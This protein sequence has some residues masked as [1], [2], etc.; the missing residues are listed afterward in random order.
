M[1][2][3][4]T[5]TREARLKS[6]AAFYDRADRFSEICQSKKKLQRI[7]TFSQ[8]YFSDLHLV[9]QTLAR[10]QGTHVVI[11]GPTGCLSMLPEDIGHLVQTSDWIVTGINERDVILGGEEKLR[12]ALKQLCS[13][14]HSSCIFVVTTPPVSVN[15][16]DVD[17][18]ANEFGS[19][20]SIPI[21]VIPATGF[22]SKLGVMGYDETQNVLSLLMTP[23]AS[24]PA[25]PYVNLISVS[26]SARDVGEAG[27]FLNRL[28][29]AV[30]ILPNF[31]GRRQLALASGARAS[32]VLNK[33]ESGCLSDFLQKRYGVPVLSFSPPVG[34]M[35]TDVWEHAVADA[36]D[37]ELPQKEQ[38]MI[39][40]NTAEN[41]Q[42][43]NVYLMVDSWYAAPYKVFLE[44]L[45]AR[46]CGITVPFLEPSSS[47][48]ETL[49]GSDAVPIHVAQGQPFELLKILDRSNPDIIICQHVPPRAPF[50]GIPC[51]SLEQ[52]GIL[53]RQAAVRLIQTISSAKEGSGFFSTLKG[54]GT[55]FY[56]PNWMKKSINWHIKLEVS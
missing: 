43:L 33:D 1:K 56:R 26:E 38:R 21:L 53:G 4:R 8:E 27:Q 10:M 22:R 47:V 3:Q 19:E 39:A 25:E 15:N 34:L 42:N 6:I 36:L 48:L 29:Y 44:S 23:P 35:A 11:H 55:A 18:I 32:L 50:S 12:I 16:D 51:V 13:Q 46:V 20:F 14:N 5:Q 9:L 40:S 37:A 52:T 54:S 7:R 41:L 28:G 30:N 49:R 31:A 24:V 17:A 45:G 2:S